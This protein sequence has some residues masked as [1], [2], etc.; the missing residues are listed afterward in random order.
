MHQG[1][2]PTLTAAPSAPGRL[3][4]GVVVVVRG[5]WFSPRVTSAFCLAESLARFVFEES[6]PKHRS[7]DRMD[8]CSS[9]L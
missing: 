2:A 9:P 4:G 5:C 6:K 8:P 1:G 3:A 7:Q